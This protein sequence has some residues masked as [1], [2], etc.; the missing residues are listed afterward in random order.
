MSHPRELFQACL[1]ITSSVRPEVDDRRRDPDGIDGQMK[2]QYRIDLLAAAVITLGLAA[3]AQ[4]REFYGPVT[5][6]DDGDSFFAAHVWHI[7]LCGVDSPEDHKRVRKQY[8]AA[9]AK[10]S[11][12]ILGKTIHCYTIKSR[13]PT[14]AVQGRAHSYR[15]IR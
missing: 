2:W 10:L 15:A 14:S 1:R 6:V 8:R 13:K 4:S 5:S 3:A 9:K 12:L 7:R 11:E